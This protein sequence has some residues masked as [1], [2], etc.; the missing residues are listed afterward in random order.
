MHDIEARAT[1]TPMLLTEP[2]SEGHLI[3]LAKPCFCQTEAPLVNYTGTK[4]LV[5]LPGYPVRSKAT[6]RRQKRCS[7][8]HRMSRLIRQH[9]VGCKCSWHRRLQLPCHALL[10]A[11]EH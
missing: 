2:L 10:H 11:L 5:V 6:Q 9:Y 3:P 8:K 4:L 7:L 1:P